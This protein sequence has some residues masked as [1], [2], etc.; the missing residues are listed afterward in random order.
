VSARA[1][2]PESR[3]VE[4]EPSGDVDCNKPE[5]EAVVKKPQPRRHQQVA[6][7]PLYPNQLM[8]CALAKF[9]AFASPSAVERLPPSARPSEPAIPVSEWG[10]IFSDSESSNDLSVL[11]HPTALNLYAI[12]TRFP[13]VRTRQLWE[14]LGDIDRRTEWDRT[15]EKAEMIERLDA[16][17][18]G[19]RRAFIS[20]IATKGMFPIRGKIII[21]PFPSFYWSPNFQCY[22][23]TAKDLVTLTV[24]ARLP[25]P[26]E[27]P[28][29]MVLAS[30]STSVEN[31]QCPAANGYSRM[32]IAVSG[33][34]VQDDEEIGGCKLTQITDFSS[35]GSKY[36]SITVG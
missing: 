12:S 36:Y 31:P 5:R 23:K 1:E 9:L 34:L 33:Y 19:S 21:C 28:N 27:R 24:E 15:C 32:E 22:G 10:C 25:P 11:A 4:P 3:R 30:A 18:T 2:P 7:H 14:A 35:L 16:K 29:H 6:E 13:G 17:Q 8:D 20:Y 26:A